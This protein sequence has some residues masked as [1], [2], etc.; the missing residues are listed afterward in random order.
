V[1]S[2]L[3]LDEHGAEQVKDWLLRGNPALEQ[4]A[5]VRRVLEGVATRID[6]RQLGVV[7]RDLSSDHVAITDPSDTTITVVITP[8]AD[9]ETTFSVLYV[10]D[11]GNLDA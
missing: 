8:Y 5:F 3:W 6:Y 4:R 10:G 1:A 7:N 11:L 2:D 9:E